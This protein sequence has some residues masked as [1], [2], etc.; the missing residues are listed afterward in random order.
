[1]VP[2]TLNALI[3]TS[4]VPLACR[5]NSA[6]E[7]L[8]VI[9]FVV[10]SDI[11]ASVMVGVLIVG[12]VKILF[13][14]DRPGHDVRYALVCEPV[15]V[16]T[17]ESIA[18]VTAFP[19]P[20]VS[21]PVPPVNVKVSE[22]KSIAR[23]PPESAWKSKSSAVSCVSTYA[24]ID[25]CVAKRVALLLDILSSSAIPVTVAPVANAKLVAELNAPATANV[26]VTSTFSAIVIFVESELSNVV[27]FTLNALNST[28]P[29]PL[30]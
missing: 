5:D 22:S 14:K 3:K 25:C 18:N 8:D 26:P 1:M 11:V 16:A 13:V 19:D 7:P 9:L 6:F 4:P 17:V 12:L 29:V 21:I 24:L 2:F 20:D 23:A 30:G 10:I 15:S 28:S 27:P